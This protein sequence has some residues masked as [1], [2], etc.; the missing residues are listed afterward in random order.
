MII[1]EELKCLA[2]IVTGIIVT[3]SIINSFKE[4]NKGNTQNAIYEML[5]TI[6][7]II[8]LQMQGVVK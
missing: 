5:K 2:K 6:L 7:F 8:L 3:I 4:K 1:A